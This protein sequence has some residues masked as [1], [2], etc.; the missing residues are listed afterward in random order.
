[1]TDTFFNR[2]L[3]GFEALPGTVSQSSGGAIARWKH[4]FPFRTE[5]LSTAAPMVLGGQPPGR[6]GRRR[7]LLT[8]QDTRPPE[9]RPFCSFGDG[10]ERHSPISGV[11]FWLVGQVRL[12]AEPF[13]GTS[14]DGLDPALASPPA[15]CSRPAT[16]CQG[17][18][19]PSHRTE[20]EGKVVFSGGHLP[21]E[22]DPGWAKCLGQRGLARPCSPRGY[23]R[24]CHAALDPCGGRRVR[25]PALTFGLRSTLVRGVSSRRA[26]R[27]CAALARPCPG[28]LSG[29]FGRVVY[30]F[31]AVFAEG[32]E[33]DNQ[34]CG[35]GCP[36]CHFLDVYEHRFVR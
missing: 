34:V 19:R 5:Q 10:M 22:L 20:T 25:R 14:L 2:P 9:G 1:M 15:R 16:G 18:F 11:S 13:G 31:E 7:F 6:V 17:P 3:C 29:S 33:L 27:P 28:P 36:G 35:I 12:P 30:V 21:A 4:L 23:G 8:K 26:L 24:S 32:G